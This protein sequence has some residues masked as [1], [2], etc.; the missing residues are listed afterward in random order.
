MKLYFEK[1]TQFSKSYMLSKNSTYKYNDDQLISQIAN[2]MGPMWGPPGSCRPQMGPM[3][4]P[5]TL[6]SGMGPL[7]ASHW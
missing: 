1:R 6:L 5:W 4:A 7:N 2:F 3:L